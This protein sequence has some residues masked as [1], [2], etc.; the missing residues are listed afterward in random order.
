[1]YY[2]G[3]GVF[4]DYQQ[5]T[6]WFLKAAKQGNAIAQNNLG[7]MFRDDEPEDY[8]QAAHWLV[9]RQTKAILKPKTI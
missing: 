6:N 3:K 5:A 2:D 4:I 8:V 9:W 1:M 7:E